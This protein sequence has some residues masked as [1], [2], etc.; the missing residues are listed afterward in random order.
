MYIIGND[1]HT[2]SCVEK[3]DLYYSTA[4]VEWK[5]RKRRRKERG[6]REI[7]SAAASA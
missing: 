5:R 1:A 2:G 3:A 4:A 7:E 6:L